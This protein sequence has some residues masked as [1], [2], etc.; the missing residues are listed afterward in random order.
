MDLQQIARNIALDINVNGETK[1]YDI[2]APDILVGSPIYKWI[3]D[4]TVICI[5]LLTSNNESMVKNDLDTIFD[6]NNKE[7]VAYNTYGKLTKNNNIRNLVLNSIYDLY[8]KFID[9][10]STAYDKNFRFN[11]SISQVLTIY[12]DSK[13]LFHSGQTFIDPRMILVTWNIN[14]A[15]DRTKYGGSILRL[16]I[17]WDQFASIL[18]IG[19]PFNYQ[20]NT[21]LPLPLNDDYD[22]VLLPGKFIINREYMKFK[23]INSYIYVFDAEYHQLDF[24]QYLTYASDNLNI[25][26]S[27]NIFNV[28]NNFVVS[29]VINIIN[30]NIQESLIESSSVSSKTLSLGWLYKFHSN[31]DDNITNSWNIINDVSDK[32]DVSHNV[33]NINNYDVESFSIRELFDINLS[34]FGHVGQNHI[35]D[36]IIVYIAETVMIPSNF[37]IPE[38]LL[39]IRPLY[40]IPCTTFANPKMSPQYDIPVKVKISHLSLNLHAKYEN[41]NIVYEQKYPILLLKPNYYEL[42]TISGYSTPKYT[43][44]PYATYDVT[45]DIIKN[46]NREFLVW[47]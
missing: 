12:V 11:G 29:D 36:E 32:N 9:F 39:S 18:S 1:G 23:Y 38:E 4:Y 15:L 13:L 28:P 14:K 45:S 6:I 7:L 16:K 5:N 30:H 33:L 22:M 3:I 42:S 31:V 44:Y 40:V 19:Y 10:S 37:I 20:I 41:G 47:Y 27:P 24:T 17:R 21:N 25:Q 43:I 2:I 26:H 46:L 34:T 35:D 8:Q